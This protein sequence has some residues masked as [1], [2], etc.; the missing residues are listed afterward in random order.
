MSKARY[1]VHKGKQKALAEQAL[2]PAG[3]CWGPPSVMGRKGSKRIWVWSSG[4]RGKY[5]LH[6]LARFL[7]AGN[8]RSALGNTS[9]I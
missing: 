3:S 8:S 7:G 4:V 2:L 5:L 9:S 6:L 1:R